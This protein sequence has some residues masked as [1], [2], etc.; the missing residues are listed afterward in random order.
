MSTPATYSPEEWQEIVNAPVLAGMLVIASDPAIFGSI[1]ESAA[2]ARTINEY[3]KTSDVELIR[4]VGQAMSGENKPHMPD[5][6]SKEGPEAV[7]KML[8]E[9]CQAAAKIVQEKSP[10][11]ADAYSRY[12]ID[13][14]KKTAESSKEGGFLG[15]GATRVSE[16]EKDAVK[17]LADAL[18]IEP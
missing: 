11:E 6:P 9:K 18:E 14:A 5:L 2:I 13:V 1:K 15:I 4:E 7:I 8:V 17:Q 3:G 12:L 10:A 16:Q